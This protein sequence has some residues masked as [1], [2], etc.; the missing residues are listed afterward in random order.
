MNE[1]GSAD[2]KV[3]TG[4]YHALWEKSFDKIR[5]PFEEFIRHQTTSG[6]MGMAVLVLV[7]ASAASPRG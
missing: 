6:L 3:I 7:L 5:T 2:T 4:V 1:E